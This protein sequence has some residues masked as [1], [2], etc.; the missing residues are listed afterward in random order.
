M[1]IVETNYNAGQRKNYFSLKDGDSVY[2]II[3]ALEMSPGSKPVWHKFYRVEFGYLKSNGRMAPFACPRKVNF[4]TKMVE[5]ESAAYLKREALKAEKEKIDAAIKAN[6]THPKIAALEAKAED[7]RET[8]ATFNSDS[9]VYV[10]AMNLQGQIGLLKMPKT[11]FD[12]LKSE[13]EKLAKA[14]TDPLGVENGRFFLISRSGVGRDTNYKVTIY[15]E[16][17]ITKIEG[18]DT[19]V[20]VPVV[21]KLTADIIA[22]LESECFDLNALYPTPTPEQ[23]ERIVAGEP[24]DEVMAIEEAASASQESADDIM[25]ELDGQD[26]AQTGSTSRDASVEA[27]LAKADALSTKEEVKAAAVKVEEKKEEV[28]VEVKAEVA[29][30]IVNAE[31]DLDALLNDL[32]K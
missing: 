5:V 9:K 8:I 27:L 25:A 30:A 12:D 14:G 20:E 11:A 7:L 19:E 24:V 13:A 1:K 4:K 18:V 26:V 32:I 28:K 29:A 6:P 2:R 10:N 23:V 3:P 16:K 17:K 21:S 31:S 22:R 15:K